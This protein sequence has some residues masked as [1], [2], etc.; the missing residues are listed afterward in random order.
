MPKKRSKKYRLIQSLRILSQIFFFTLFFYLLLKTHFPGKDYIGQVEIFFHFD[1]LLA[2]TTMLAARAVFFSFIFASAT[3]V[4]TFVLG[5]VVC[6]WV[7]PLG[8]IHQFFSFLFKKSKLLQPQP[9]KKQRVVKPTLK[10]YILIFVLVGAVFS[11]DLVGFID[12][13]SLLYRSLAVSFLPAFNYGFNALI[14][15]IYQVHLTSLADSLVQFNENLAVNSIFIQG[16]LIGLIFGV[17]ILFNL[18]YERFWCRYLC[19]LGALLG[20]FSRW[21]I[22]K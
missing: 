12:P 16:F 19:P 14:S 7:C 20:V 5:R 3:I 10:Y 21:N 17:L 13:L 4:L 9:V 8:S 18:L 1:P 6:G 11:L 2:L 22:F 15:L